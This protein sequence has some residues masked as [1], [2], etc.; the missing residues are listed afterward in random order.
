MLEGGLPVRVA[1][2]IVGAVGVSGATSGDK[3]EICTAKGIKS[4][5]DRLD[6][7]G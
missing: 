2:S 4:V 6:F 7:A 3:D 5:Q 1:G